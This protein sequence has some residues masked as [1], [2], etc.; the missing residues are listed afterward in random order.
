MFKTAIKDSDNSD[1]IIKASLLSTPPRS[2]LSL[3]DFRPNTQIK[4]NLSAVPSRPKSTML[5]KRNNHSTLN[6]PMQSNIIKA[7]SLK[8]V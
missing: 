4:N 2:K 5:G 1:V 8:K 3:L 7:S 6:S